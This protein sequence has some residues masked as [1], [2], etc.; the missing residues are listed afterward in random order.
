VHGVE[1]VVCAAIADELEAL[2]QI[3][4]QILVVAERAEMTLEPAGALEVQERARVVHDGGDLRTAAD[5]AFI[6]RDFID[7]AVAHPGHAFDP[8]PVERGLDPSPLGIDDAPA[9]ARLEDPL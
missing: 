7:L 5:P 2:L 6:P 9:D 8:E 4:G 3:G 1:E